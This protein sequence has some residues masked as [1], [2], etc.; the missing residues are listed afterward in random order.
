MQ[1]M[2]VAI[3]IVTFNRCEMLRDL[4][5][6]ISKLEYQPRHV[7]VVDNASSDGTADFLS[8]F[9]N[10]LGNIELH[11]IKSNTNLGGSGGFNI[12]LAHA[13]TLD[14]DWFWI[15]DDD[16]EVLPDGLTSLIK[17]GDKFKC[18]HGRRYDVDGSEFFWQPRFNEFLGIPLP[19]LSNPFKEGDVFFTNSGCFEGMFIHKDVVLSIGLPDERFFIT[20]DDAIYGWLASKKFDVVYVNEFVLQRKKPQ[21]QISLGFR[22][23]NGGSPLFC[24]YVIRNRSLVK[25]YLKNYGRYSSVGFFLG[26]CI[27]FLKEVFRLVFIDRSFSNLRAIF[28]GLL[29]GLCIS[30][31]GYFK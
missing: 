24:Y 16:V 26:G 5:A 9:N 29:D 7:I 19:Y 8:Q 3:V 6:S 25:I 22:H 12:G 4:M 31:R 2:T 11:C 30:Y 15:M 18:I 28:S 20:W 17:Y 10:K 23:M 1:N 13:L 14:A 21:N 27:N